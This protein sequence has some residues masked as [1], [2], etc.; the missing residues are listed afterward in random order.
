MK[1]K[2]KKECYKN[3]ID[4]CSIIMKPNIDSKAI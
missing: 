2:R 4:T 1:K 3:Y